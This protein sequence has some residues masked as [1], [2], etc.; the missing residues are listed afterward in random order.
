M[1]G[2]ALDVDAIYACLWLAVTRGMPFARLAGDVAEPVDWDAAPFSAGG[3][4]RT[5]GSCELKEQCLT[6]FVLRPDDVWTHLATMAAICGH[7]LVLVQ[8]RLADNGVDVSH[9]GPRL[10]SSALLDFDDVIEVPRDNRKLLQGLGATPQ[11]HPPTSVEGH[12]AVFHENLSR[13]PSR[14]MD[15]QNGE[16]F[17]R[18]TSATAR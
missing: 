7:D 1:L 14:G 6:P 3:H 16:A 18:A 11:D 15:T 2:G 12:Y 13:K 8:D 10:R 17:A 9:G 5:T 4:T